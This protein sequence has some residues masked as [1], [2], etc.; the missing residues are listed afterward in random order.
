MKNY[1]LA[2]LVAVLLFFMGWQG[3]FLYISISESANNSTLLDKIR[4]KKRLDVVILNSPTVYYMGPEKERGFEYELIS[5]YAKEIGV[6]LNLTIVYSINEAI[7]K[8]RE[9]VGDITVASISKTQDTKKEF[10]FGPQYYTTQELLICNNSLYKKGIFPRDIDDLA[11]LNIVVAKDTSYETT[12]S[13]LS[14]N[15]NN[16]NYVATAKY[17]TEQLLELTYQKKIDCT[18]VDSNI[19]MINQRYYPELLRTLVL[20]DKKKLA[21]VLREGDDSLKKSLYEWL[22]NYEYLGKM[23]EL[24]EFYY[25]FLEMFD[26][27]DTKVFYKRLRSRLPKYKKYFL[28]AEE[29]YNIPWVLL[30]AL[31][32]Q[33]SHW[34][35]R[36]TSYTGVRG[37]MMLTKTTAKQMGVKNRLSAKESIYGGAKYLSMLEKNFPKEVK[38]KNRWA[39]TL[40]AY[41]VGMGHIHDAQ[42]L[43]RKLNKNPYSWSEIKKVLPLLSQKKYYKSLKYGYA[44]GEEPVRYVNSIQHY[45]DMIHKNETD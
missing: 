21:W 18:V 16:L 12:M 42:T 44:R 25:S 20:N 31:S 19:F 29:K 27:Y 17:S 28:D 5:E 1:K 39:F 32:Y 10:V 41:N 22:N 4:A 2:L 23:S 45:L 13:K 43:A 7:Q 8:S 37:M 34:N 24:K 38:G 30:A 15:V 35:P 36:A 11:G 14:T 3:A 40:A 6:D 33:E 26:Y 9:G